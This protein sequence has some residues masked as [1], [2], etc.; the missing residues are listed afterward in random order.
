ML[1]KQ[2]SCGRLKN[3]YGDFLLQQV[4]ANG[5]LSHICIFHIC[6]D[7]SRHNGYD[8]SIVEAVNL[9]YSNPLFGLDQK[10][11]PDQHSGYFLQGADATGRAQAVQDSLIRKT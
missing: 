1:S 7:T 2:L 10:E 4:I 11:L 3:S 6:R 8:D 5:S 9:C